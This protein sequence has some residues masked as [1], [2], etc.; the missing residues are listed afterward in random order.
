MLTF[1]TNVGKKEKEKDEIQTKE[2]WCRSTVYV[3]NLIMYHMSSHLSALFVAFLQ[4]WPDS[5]REI[6]IAKP[7]LHC[8]PAFFPVVWER[9]YRHFSINFM[10][11]MT[12]TLVITSWCAFVLTWSLHCQN[13]GESSTLPPFVSGKPAHLYMY[14]IEERRMFAQN[15]TLHLSMMNK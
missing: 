15:R 5:V 4:V 8:Y 12:N 2:K 9:I 3:V 10:Y 11:G 13:K 6:C 14:S 7:F 1:K